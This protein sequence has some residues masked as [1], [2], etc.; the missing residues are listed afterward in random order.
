MCTDSGKTGVIKTQGRGLGLLRRARG[1]K[2]EMEYRDILADRIT[3]SVVRQVYSDLTSLY[4]AARATVE[5]KL[6]AQRTSA[7]PATVAEY[8]ARVPSLVTNEFRHLM[9]QIYP[10]QS[11]RQRMANQIEKAAKAIFPSLEK[12]LVHHNYFTARSMCLAKCNTAALE[13]LPANLMITGANFC[14]RLVLTVLQS[15]IEKPILIDHFALPEV[16]MNGMH[17]CKQRIAQCVLSTLDAYLPLDY[18]FSVAHETESES[19]NFQRDACLILASIRAQN[20]SA[21]DGLRQL[22][23]FK[24]NAEASAKLQR[25][26]HARE[27]QQLATSSRK[28]HDELK[29]QMED[30][31]RQ[32]R[33]LEARSK[34]TLA[35]KEAEIK[36][37]SAAPPTAAAS[38]SASAQASNANQMAFVPTVMAPHVPLAV[39][40]PPPAIPVAPVGSSSKSSSSSPLQERPGG[41]GEFRSSYLPAEYEDRDDDYEDEEEGYSKTRYA[42]YDETEYDDEPPR[43][44]GQSSALDFSV[45]AQPS[46]S[47]KLRASP[48]SE[49]V[50]AEEQRAV[51]TLAVLPPREPQPLP[52]ATSATSPGAEGGQLQQQQPAAQAQAP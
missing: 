2:K 27:V 17:E 43:S 10:D 36:R 28:Q 52:A 9:N 45:S 31:Q 13:K 40:P 12:A 14:E 23:A 46:A 1:K 20:A 16:Q 38:S 8:N 3:D 4:N 19:L 34:E 26:A 6:E 49:L 29:A 22:S 47:G 21:Q 51:A 50:E 41:G 25:E 33:Q 11:Q 24:E 15:F 39:K 37:L 32:M 48:S 44:Q 5:H 7:N 18:I 30:L 42:D 35:Q